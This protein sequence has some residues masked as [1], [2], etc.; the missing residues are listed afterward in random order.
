M[1]APSALVQLCESWASLYSDSKLVAT[2]VVF[3]HV[4]AMM[5]AGGL[6]ITIDRGTLRAAR[7]SSDRGRQ[8]TEIGG[9]HRFV[10]GGLIVSALSG[11][12]L[13][14]SD[15]ETYWVSW[16]YWT[17]M[18]LIVALL[19]NGFMMTRAEA[20]AQQAGAPADAGWARLKLTAVASI[21]LWFLIALFGVTLV[22]AA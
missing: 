16:V 7:N 14:A 3:F 9:A 15:V 12:L 10:I 5:F 1:T 4:G 2:I 19:L 6:A 13:F 21:A 22:N 18:G 17:K 11:L 20:A 8:L